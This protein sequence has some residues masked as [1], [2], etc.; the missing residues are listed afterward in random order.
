MKKP[1]KHKTSI[2]KAIDFG[3]DVTLIY[4]RLKL[5]PTERLKKHEQALEFAEELKRAGQKNRGQS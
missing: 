4:E 5:T 2:Q 3:I 1:K